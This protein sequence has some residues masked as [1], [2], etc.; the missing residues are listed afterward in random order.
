[1]TE[2]TEVNDA[3]RHRRSRRL[4]PRLAPQAVVALLVISA[5]GLSIIAFFVLPPRL[6]DDQRFA[7]AKPT[8]RAANEEKRLKA[9]NDVRTAGLQLIGALALIVGGAFTWR[10]VW[11][12]R[13]GQITD[14]FAKAIEQ[15]GLD[16]QETKSCVGAIYAL[17]RVARDS[18]TDHP[19]VMEVLADHLRQRSP[20]I[21]PEGKPLELEARRHVDSDVKAVATVLRQR[22]ASREIGGARLDLSG[23]DLRLAPLH[24]VD[25]RDADLR[26]SN[27]RGAY[28]S[29]GDLRGALLMNA[30]LYNANLQRAKL[31]DANLSGADLSYA[32]ATGAR[33]KR[34]DF[35]EAI[36]DQTEFYGAD[37]AGAKSLPA[38]VLE[39]DRVM[40]DDGTVWP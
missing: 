16:A 21:D 23:I 5:T 38:Q 19:A 27:L 37:L 1:M 6:V 28:L 3:R 10:T 15:L 35:D 22:R 40:A 12:T 26:G 39:D 24:G 2:S 4:A 31:D 14:R 30:T 9:R 32:H 18:R 33:F 25:L 29:D 17:G 7:A 36:F 8:S 13:E 34:A 20:A 11:L